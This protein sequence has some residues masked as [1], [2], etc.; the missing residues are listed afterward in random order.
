M[1]E[2]LD[3]SGVTALGAPRLKT[4]TYSCT[5]SSAK[6]EQSANGNRML[7]VNYTS[8]DGQGEIPDRFVVGHPDAEIRSLILGRLKGM[9][10]AAN[11]S[12]PDQFRGPSSLARHQL[13]VRVEQDGS[14]TDKKTG[15]SRPSYAVK[16]YM[17]LAEVATGAEQTEAPKSAAEQFDEDIPF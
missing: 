14:F 1:S 2:T 17:P 5:I 15:E 3:L 11:Y 13:N 7:V 6:W 4:G 10:L 8:N 16:G 12:N 9:L